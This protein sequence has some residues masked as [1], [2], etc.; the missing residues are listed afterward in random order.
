MLEDP[1][2]ALFGREETLR[3]GDWTPP[4]DISETPEE[5]TVVAEVPGIEPEEIDVTLEDHV[6]HIR[7]EK[8]PQRDVN[9]QGY[10]RLERRYGPFER[11]VRIPAN[12]DGDRIAATAREGLLRIALPKLPEARPRRIAVAAG[13][14][15]GGE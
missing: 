4:M 6:L 14:G 10:Y 8:R 13:T 3:R 7:G 5:Y 9:E 15:E 2:E 11:A 12:I 1:L